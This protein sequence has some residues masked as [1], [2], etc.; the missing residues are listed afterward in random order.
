MAAAHTVVPS[1]VSQ[2]LNPP[3]PATHRPVGPT[4]ARPSAARPLSHHDVDEEESKG[5]LGTLAAIFVAH[6]F[7]IL[8]LAF[9]GLGVLIYNS[10]SAKQAAAK[11]SPVAVAAP[12]APQATPVAPQAIPVAPQATLGIPEPTP[13]MRSEPLPVTAV[14][15]TTPRAP[16]PEPPVE[17]APSSERQNPDRR[18]SFLLDAQNACAGLSVGAACSVTGPRGHQ[19]TG[20]CSTGPAGALACKPDFMPERGDSSRGGGFRPAPGER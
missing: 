15:A 8:F 10:Y 17:P 6:P 1:P 20:R 13:M 19:A 3:K 2:A 18:R 9:G 14:T 4:T 11:A 5:L 16:E 12:A 7:L